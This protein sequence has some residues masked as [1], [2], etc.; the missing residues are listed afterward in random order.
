MT[1]ISGRKNGFPAGNRQR[2]RNSGRVGQ[3]C[4]FN[5]GRGFYGRSCFHASPDVS[6][7]GRLTYVINITN[8]QRARPA[9]GKGPRPCGGLTDIGGYPP[10]TGRGRGIASRCHRA[11]YTP[12]TREGW[13][14]ADT[15]V[16]SHRP[17]KGRA[18]STGS[19]SL[20]RGR[21]KADH[22]G[23]SRKWGAARAAGM[24]ANSAAIHRSPPAMPGVAR[25][26]EDTRCRD[27]GNS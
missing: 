4:R 9:G 10:R 21:T 3:R 26:P 25:I 14:G 6:D 2:E 22:G 24:P 12:S 16:Q 15:P 19:C 13:Q 8:L 27:Q 23:R 20:P 11:P 7:C 1:A 5:R 17:L 18:R